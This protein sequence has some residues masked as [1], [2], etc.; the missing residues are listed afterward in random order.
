MNRN[1]KATPMR[2]LQDHFKTMNSLV[3]NM[4]EPY[5]LHRQEPRRG[6]DWGGHRVGARKGVFNDFVKIYQ[7]H[8]DNADKHWSIAFEFNYLD[9]SPATVCVN[10]RNGYGETMYSKTFELGDFRLLMNKLNK[11]LKN[12]AA[13]LGVNKLSQLDFTLIFEDH[14]LGNENGIDPKELEVNISAK[15]KE[16]EAI[17][18]EHLAKMKAKEVEKN[19]FL[20]KRN[21]IQN[22]ISSEI[23]NSKENQRMLEINRQI[24]E[25]Q[26]E[27]MALGAQL[28]EME[29]DKKVKAKIAGI[30][31]QISAIE[32]D[33][34]AV[35]QTVLEQIRKAVSDLPSAA[36]RNM[37]KGLTGIN[38]S[39]NKY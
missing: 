17:W 32:N 2:Q 10:K 4:P 33:M 1:K 20:I 31:N 13:E 35:N 28:A 22:N 15:R 7:N 12:R 11:R 27:Q 36:Q 14:F 9:I 23:F 34:K 38:V 24:L 37:I 5:C 21:K 19:K 29:S 30:S 16:C 26:K 8:S 3:E 25:L 6:F 39:R 18:T